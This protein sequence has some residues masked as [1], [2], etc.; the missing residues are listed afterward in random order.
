M[1]AIARN[2]PLNETL[3]PDNGRRA[4]A[5]GGYLRS[6]IKVLLY[7]DTGLDGPFWAVVMIH[8]ILRLLTRTI[9]PA[10]IL[11]LIGYATLPLPA[12][13]S[14]AGSSVAFVRGRVRDAGHQTS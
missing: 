11:F 9:L 12:T 2:H 13:A 8:P 1:R 3:Y 6:A 10:A 7:G 4:N 5:R 14:K